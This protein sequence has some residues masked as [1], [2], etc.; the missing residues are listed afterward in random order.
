MFA[1]VLVQSVSKVVLEYVCL[2]LIGVCLLQKHCSVFAR[3][4]QRR[5]RTS[6]MINS[7]EQKP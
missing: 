3:V 7:E 2:N 6:E 4:A 1:I 5:V